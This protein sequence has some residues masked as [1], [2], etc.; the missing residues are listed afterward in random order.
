MRRVIPPPESRDLTETL[1]L[2]RVKYSSKGGHIH[3]SRQG[4]CP[5]LCRASVPEAPVPHKMAPRVLAFGPPARTAGG[6]AY[7]T[8][9]ARIDNG[10]AG[11]G[12]RRWSGPCAEIGRHLANARFRQPGLGVNSRGIDDHRRDPNN[13]VFNNLIV[14][15]QHVLQNS[16]ASIVPNLAT[17]WRWSEDGKELIFPLLHGVKWHDGTP[18]TAADVKCT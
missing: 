4:C 5:A 1:V 6:R 17:E 16:L 8:I 7:G 11:S 3:L 9:P 15:D 18:F 13:G 14:S 10:F 12:V 2:S